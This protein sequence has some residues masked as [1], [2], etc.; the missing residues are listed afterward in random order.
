MQLIEGVIMDFWTNFFKYLK[1]LSL[2]KTRFPNQ[3]YLI[4]AKTEMIFSKN[5]FLSLLSF[6]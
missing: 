6:V 2:A 1:S 4:S 5:I 3:N